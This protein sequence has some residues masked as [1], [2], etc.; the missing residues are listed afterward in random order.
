VPLAFL[1]KIADAVHEAEVIPGDDQLLHLIRRH[2]SDAFDPVV[3][4]ITNLGRVW[5]VLPFCILVVVYLSVRRQL[6]R[7]EFF[8][9]AT[10][11]P[12]SLNLLAKLFFG[13]DRPALWE[14]PVP[15]FDY[16]FPSGHAMVTMAVGLALVLLTW[17]TRARW[18]AI[19]LGGVL[20]FLIGLSRLYLGVHYPSDVLAGWCA[21]VAWVS[22]VHFLLLERDHFRIRRS[23]STGGGDAATVH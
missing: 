20:V 22:G 16:G 15:E 12:A 18:F 17:E 23:A 13:R 11:G 21:S 19:V 3:I 2:A 14:S 1:A 4:A 7:V 5:I 6:R 10:L 9:D 8:V